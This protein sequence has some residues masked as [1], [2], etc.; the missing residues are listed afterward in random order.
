MKTIKNIGIYAHV[1]AGKT[2]LTEHL[3]LNCGAIRTAGRVDDGNTQ[4]DTL[5]VERKRGISVRS[6]SAFIEY[7]DTVINLIDTPGHVDFAG[8]VERSLAAVDGA[9]LI[10]SA[11]E[12]VQ[13]HTEALWKAF[14]RLKLPRVVFINKIDRAGSDTDRVIAEMNRRLGAKLVKITKTESEGNRSC[15]ITPETDVGQACELLGE[16]DDEIAEY[17]LDGKSPPAGAIKKALAKAAAECSVFPVCCGSAALGIGVENLLGAVADY[18]PSEI[19]ESGEPSGVVFKLEHDRDIGK[20]AY[21][22]LFSG[23]LKNRDTVELTRRGERV[24]NSGEKITQIRKWSAKGSKYVDVGMVGG[25][26]I[27]AVCGLGDIRVGDIVGEAAQRRGLTGAG[28]KLANPFLTVKVQPPSPEKLTE[29]IT[30]LRELSEEDPLINCRWEK[31]ER[32]VNIDLTGKIQLEIID[33]ILRERYGLE[34]TFSPPSVIYRETI[35]KPG[36]GFEAYTMPKPCWAIVALRFEPLPRGSGVVY[37]GGH[38]PNNQLFYRYQEHIK[39][40]FFASLSQGNYGWEVTDFKATLT[41]GEHHTIHTHPLD[42]FVATPVAVRRA[43][44]N[45]G[46]TMLEPLL[47]VRIAAPEDYLGKAVGDVTGMRGEFDTPVVSG[48]SFEM[49]CV[50]P[51]STSLEYPVKLARQTSGKGGFSS[52]FY[53]YR[54]IPPELGATTPFRGIDPLDRAKWILYARGAITLDGGEGFKG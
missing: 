46:T 48:G 26:D 13:A 42:F 22:R 27:A 49:E 34:A 3:L 44:V 29:L 35:A 10:V 7:G 16:T 25:G 23:S 53:G 28:V 31:T 6:A 9:V 4:T 47:K 51:V 36:D 37:D 14:D 38:V 2:T 18:I 15:K 50:L 19:S 17:Y 8:E 32:E 21:V 41:G 11:V 43:F 12:G 33:A 5:D 54:E 1:D 24:E 20:V 45:C 39:K 30:A 40:S 52:E